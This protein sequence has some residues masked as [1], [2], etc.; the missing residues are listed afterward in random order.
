MLDPLSR[1][2]IHMTRQ[3]KP[4]QNND[5]QILFIGIIK[6]YK[7]IDLLI[8]TVPLLINRFNQKNFKIVIRG[9]CSQ[10]D[11]EKYLSTI[12]QANLESNID[13]AIKNLETAKSIMN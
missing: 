1:P 10:R 9:H 3:E 13:F 8:E 5:F 4:N 12:N 11:E 7:G 2:H 6:P